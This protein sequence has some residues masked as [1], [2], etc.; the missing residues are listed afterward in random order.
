MHTLVSAVSLLTVHR[1]LTY[2]FLPVR[3]VASNDSMAMGG[4]FGRVEMKSAEAC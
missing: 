4:G 1:S 3:F 2:S